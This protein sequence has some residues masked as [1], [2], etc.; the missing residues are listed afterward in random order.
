MRKSAWGA[1][2]VGEQ[3]QNAGKVAPLLFL[4]HKGD[5]LCVTGGYVV[6]VPLLV[7]Q[8]AEE[9]IEKLTPEFFYSRSGTGQGLIL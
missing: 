4:A 8:L 9:G 1:G 3:L 5:D 7:G 6:V 2:S